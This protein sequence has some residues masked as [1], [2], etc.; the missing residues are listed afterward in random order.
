MF[1]G[2]RRNAGARARAGAGG[3]SFIGTDMQL[4]GDVT[5]AA[6]VHVDGRVDGHVRCDTLIMG[7]GGVIAGD[8]DADQ[9]RIAG[10]V[11]GMVRARIVTLET[12]ARVTGDVTYETL[13]IA[14]GALIEGRVAHL[15]ML[16]PELA[17]PE[18]LSAV[19]IVPERKRERR[20]LAPAQPVLPTLAAP[21]QA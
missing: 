6:A 15:G 10:L 5:S 21:A 1:S 7:Q 20:A 8:I 11:D 12:T 2:G 14:A 17:Q 18:L 19:E 9:V 3:L 13:A 4:R 16:G